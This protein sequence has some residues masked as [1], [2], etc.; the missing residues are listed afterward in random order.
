MKTS[1]T[2]TNSSF[3]DWGCIQVNFSSSSLG[4]RKKKI[5]GQI[6]CHDFVHTL[7]EFSEIGFVCVVA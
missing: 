5:F 3:N 6:S 4:D 1:S 7:N 2:P